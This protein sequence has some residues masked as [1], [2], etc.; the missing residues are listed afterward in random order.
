M[1]LPSGRGVVY[2]AQLLPDRVMAVS[3][4]RLGEAEAARL[5]RSANPTRGKGVKRERKG[6]AGSGYEAVVRTQPSCY[7]GR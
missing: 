3:G 2:R 5:A 7:L 1:V 6:E 4:W